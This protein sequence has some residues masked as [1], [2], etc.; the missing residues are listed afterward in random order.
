MCG[1]EGRVRDHRKNWISE[2]KCPAFE[3]S[4]TVN[5]ENKL[6]NYKRRGV[7]DLFSVPGGGLVMSCLSSS[8]PSKKSS[9]SLLPLKLVISWHLLHK[10]V[11][12]VLYRYML[13]WRLISTFPEPLKI[14]TPFPFVPLIS[15]ITKPVHSAFQ[16]K[17]PAFAENRL[18]KKDFSRRNI[19]ILPK[20]SGVLVLNW[21]L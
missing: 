9:P 3:T 8:W 1:K 10:I 19:Y 18:L 21:C 13:I 2:K 11:A 14:E 16:R 15:S 4:M 7:K 17:K 5:S 12:N 6:T 20:Y